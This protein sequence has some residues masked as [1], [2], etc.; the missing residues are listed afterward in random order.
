MDT[1]EQS[2]FDLVDTYVHLADDGAAE[3][4]D[5]DDEFWTQIEHRTALHQGRLLGAFHMTES[6]DHWEMHPHGDEILV[7]LSGSVDVILNTR[8]EQVVALRKQGSCIVPSGVWHRQLVHEPSEMIFITPG[9]ETQHRP[10]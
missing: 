8:R 10:L 9:R 6:P 1:R 7:L 2:G 4:I 3:V 5:V